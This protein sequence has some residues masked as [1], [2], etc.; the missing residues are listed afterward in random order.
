MVIKLHHG[1]NTIMSLLHLY[2]NI[3]PLIPYYYYIL[4]LIWLSNIII[5]EG[6]GLYTNYY[7]LL[8][9]M[10]INIDQYV[11]LPD[12][13][14]KLRCWCPGIQHSIRCWWTQSR[15]L[16]GPSSQSFGTSLIVNCYPD[17]R[18]VQSNPEEFYEEQ[19]IKCSG[20]VSGSLFKRGA[21]P[22]YC[23]MLVGSK[24]KGE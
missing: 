17:S 15:C 11:C 16:L 14:E 7:V 10:F 4:Q 3:M 21:N 6:G 2:V 19:A 23:G 12:L 8:L 1:Y 24:K 18:W 20:K 13:V 5:I 22:P 9:L